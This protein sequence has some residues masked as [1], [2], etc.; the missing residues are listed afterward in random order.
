[1]PITDNFQ[2]NC[3]F[4]IKCKFTLGGISANKLF[5]VYVVFDPQLYE[6]KTAMR[7]L[8]TKYK[9]HLKKKIKIIGNMLLD[10]FLI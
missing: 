4:S 3:N 2:A 10:L 9:V 7:I 6:V 1:M 5:N 8:A